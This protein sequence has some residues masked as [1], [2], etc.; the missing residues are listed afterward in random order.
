M[1]VN[2]HEYGPFLFKNRTRIKSETYAVECVHQ[3]VLDEHCLCQGHE[4]RATFTQDKQNSTQSSQ[5]SVEDCQHCSL[6]KVGEEEHSCSNAD[7]EGE[8]GEELRHERL[9]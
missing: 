1:S 7:P 8:G 2:I 4:D 3:A 9:P 5:W 6:R